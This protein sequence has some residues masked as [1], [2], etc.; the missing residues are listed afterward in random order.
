MIYNCDLSCYKHL[1]ERMYEFRFNMYPFA[2]NYYGNR[3]LLPL[4]LLQ[5]K[6]G[7]N[8]LNIHSSVC[9]L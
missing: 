3:F 1:R 9:F 5:E 8:V 6:R 7:L 4:M 2:F